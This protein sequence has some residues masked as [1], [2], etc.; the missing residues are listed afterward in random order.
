MPLPAWLTGL[1]AKLLLIAAAAGAFLLAV[2]KIRQ[3]GADAQ[4]VEQQKANAKVEG[5][6]EAVRPPA[7]GETEKRLEEGRF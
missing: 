6:V 4:R 5:R 2:L 1:P 3:G 7:P